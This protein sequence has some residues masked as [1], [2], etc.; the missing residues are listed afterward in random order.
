MKLKYLSILLCSLALF[1]VIGCT[2]FNEVK[3]VPVAEGHDAVIVN[4]ERAQRG[5]LEVYKQVTEW[6]LSSRAILPVEVSRVV[7]QFRTHFPPAW[8]QSRT[9]LLE[10]K[11]NRGTNSSAIARTTA[12][13]LATR[14]SLLSLKRT[15][16]RNEA[17]EAITALH[18][19]T[20]TFQ[21]NP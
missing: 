6:E 13:L 20:N 15:G 2:S 4:A 14:T 9:A 18:T 7:D 1:T 3:P 19:L 16:E 11:T 17:A 12:A 8:R 21:L 10:Y 5:S